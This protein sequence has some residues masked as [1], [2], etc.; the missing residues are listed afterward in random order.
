MYVEKVNQKKDI[1]LIVYFPTY[2][3]FN[4]LF[5][6]KIF[7][8]NYFCM[9]NNHDKWIFDSNGSLHQGS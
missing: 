3:D 1:C 9:R 8:Q 5:E 4:L 2:F 7:Y 6:Y